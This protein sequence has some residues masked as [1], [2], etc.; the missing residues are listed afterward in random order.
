MEQEF[1]QIVSKIHDQ[2]EYQIQVV[3]SSSFQDDTK[4]SLL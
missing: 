1:A 3:N 4:R 2:Q